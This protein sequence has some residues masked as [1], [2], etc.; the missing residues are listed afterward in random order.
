MTLNESRNVLRKS[1]FRESEIKGAF[2]FY[3]YNKINGSIDYIQITIAFMSKALK[4][5][6]DLKY[7]NLFQ[8]KLQ[9]CCEHAMRV[10]L[11]KLYCCY[12]FE[13]V[14]K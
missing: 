4:V 7:I 11:Q 6:N 1:Y 10:F 8:N 2:M 12:L 14:P 3:F 9:L 13:L 5:N